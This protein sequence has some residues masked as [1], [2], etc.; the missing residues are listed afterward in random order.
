MTVPWLR[1]RSVFLIE[2]RTSWLVTNAIRTIPTTV[3]AVVTNSVFDSMNE[4]IAA[5]G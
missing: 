3:A 4:D 2:R 1:L 5:A